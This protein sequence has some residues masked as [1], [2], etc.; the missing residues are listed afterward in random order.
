VIYDFLLSLLADGPILK[1]TLKLFGILGGLYVLGQIAL[2]LKVY[3]TPAGVLLLVW[4]TGRSLK[5]PVCLF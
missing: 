5:R 4:S 3:N 2:V 1:T